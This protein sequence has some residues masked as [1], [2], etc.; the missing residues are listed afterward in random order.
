MSKRLGT[1]LRKV[2]AEGRQEGVVTGGRGYGELTADTIT[3]LTKYYGNAMPFN[4]GSEKT[5]KETT[6]ALGFRHGKA[7]VKL[8]QAKDKE[9]LALMRRK[10]DAQERK[11]R[12][13]RRL[14]RIRQQDMLAQAEGELPMVLESFRTLRWDGHMKQTVLFRA[15]KP[16]GSFQSQLHLHK[17]FATYLINVVYIIK[18]WYFTYMNSPIDVYTHLN[19]QKP[20]Q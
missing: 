17:E 19:S 5:V 18:K 2:A 9:T 11:N 20:F 10:A 14:H 4:Q 7:I 8:T 15:S 16:N 13:Y 1:A 12:G 6:A 3:K